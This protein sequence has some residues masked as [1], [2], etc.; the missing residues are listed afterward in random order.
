MKNKNEKGIVSI[1]VLFAM[2]LLLIFVFSIYSLVDNKLK[3]NEKQNLNLLKIYS[4]KLDLID[5]NKSADNQ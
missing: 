5:S 4:N 1:F 2:M 3:E